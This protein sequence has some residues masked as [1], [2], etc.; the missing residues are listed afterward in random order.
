M[1]HV[2]RFVTRFLIPAALAGILCSCAGVSMDI[3][4]RGDGSGNAVMEYRVSKAMESLG[5]LDG[6]ER[7]PLVPV[8]RADFQ[9]TM[10]RLP[11]LKLASFS[12]SETN[13]DV[14]TRA[15][16]SF[17]RFDDMLAFLDQSP[18]GAKVTYSAENGK[19][20]LAVIVSEGN[21]GIDADLLSLVDTLFSG[22]TLNFSVH[23][24]GTASAVLTDT[25]GKMLTADNNSIPQSVHITQQGKNASVSMNMADLF[26]FPDGLGLEFTW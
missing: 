7:W 8:G 10:A 12:S 2:L 21:A 25:N 6:N 13:T 19:T 5:K 11:N 18:S 15:D 23:V 20:R 24:P 22:Y 9:R 26:G 16:I 4:V 14:I 3:T 1:H 17:H